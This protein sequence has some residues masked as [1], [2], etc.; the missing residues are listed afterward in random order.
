MKQFFFLA[1]CFLFF[2]S[3]LLAQDYIHKKNGAVDTAKILEINEKHVVYKRWNYEDGPTFSTLVKEINYIQFG[4]GSTEKFD[5]N[6]QLRPFS[7]KLAANYHYGDNII[8]VLPIFISNIGPVGIGIS[9]ERFLDKNQIFALSLP[10]AYSYNAENFNYNYNGNERKLTSFSAFPGGKF[11]PARRFDGKVS[12]G[13][14]VAIAII[15]GT[16]QED[17]LV[18]NPTTQTSQLMPL[19]NNFLTMGPMITNSLNMQPSSKIY[20]GLE[21]GIGFPYFI[22][23]S[24]TPSNGWNDYVYTPYSSDEPI[25]Q[26]NFKIGYRF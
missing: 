9:Y 21:F 15:S 10:I 5:T 24:Q 6:E 22:N 26:F 3:S 20:L 12:Y 4:N 16:A 23:E 13:L 11:Y 14:G 17:R 25:V 7:R 18:Y 1:F 2:S 8:A 19:K